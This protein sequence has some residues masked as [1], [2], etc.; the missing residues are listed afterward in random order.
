M[1]RRMFL[2]FTLALLF[3]LGQQG[4]AAHAISHYADWQ[5]QQQDKSHTTSTCDKCVVYAQLVGA[6]PSATYV[7]PPAAQTHALFASQ[8]FTTSAFTHPAYAARAP[9]LYS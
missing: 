3:G 6:M 4:A 8:I 5:E 9:P 1:L 2:V 7:L